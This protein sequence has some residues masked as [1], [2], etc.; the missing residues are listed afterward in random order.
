MRT[1][2]LTD[3]KYI[4]TPSEGLK[5]DRHSLKGVSPDLCLDTLAQLDHKKS[6]K[7]LQLN[8]NKA[9]E[10]G[11]KHLEL[12]KKPFI[13]RA[14]SKA[15]MDSLI[16]QLI[17][18]KSPFEDAYWSTWHCARVILQEGNTLKSK[19]CKQRWCGV[20]NNIRTANLMNG[21]REPLKTL[22]DP[23]LVT[24]TIPNVKGTRL[25]STIEYM[26]KNF[27]LI[28]RALE[29][30]YKIKIRGIRK[31]E[32]TYN[33]KTDT[34]HPH[35]HIIIEGEM[36]SKEFV[37]EWLNRYPKA[38]RSAQDIRRAKKG[39]MHELFKYFTKLVTKESFHPKQMDIIFRAMKGKRVFQPYGLKK[40]VSEEIEDIQKQETTHLG[41]QNEI[42]VWEENS[43]DWTDSTGVVVAG[44]TPKPNY[45]EYLDK[46]KE[47]KPL[48]VPDY[49]PKESS[50][51][52]PNI[53]QVY[54]PDEAFG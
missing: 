31:I 46:L 2:I 33:A 54:S 13:K 27:V 15:F 34:Y 10:K 17:D 26:Q 41:F 20:C 9:L 35:F 6:T 49:E 14:R 50:K 32:C 42:Y 5:N 51:N 24:L 47:N 38:T 11:K 52:R 37:G 1:N 18:L 4:S 19:F 45:L 21:Y 12:S 39:S 53:H 43:Y 22:K 48:K 23:Q 3:L 16:Y 8:N 7:A 25:Q 29:R 30:K 28:K 44:Y 40:D 36:I